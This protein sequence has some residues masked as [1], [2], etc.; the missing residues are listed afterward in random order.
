M[1]FSLCFKFTF[2]DENQLSMGVRNGD[3]VG[4]NLII[5]SGNDSCPPLWH[6]ALSNRI[7]AGSCS[8]RPFKTD[9]VRPLKTTAVVEWKSISWWNMPAQSEIA[10]ISVTFPPRSPPTHCYTNTCNSFSKVTQSEQIE[11]G[12]YHVRLMRTHVMLSLFPES[13]SDAERLCPILQWTIVR[14]SLWKQWHQ[15]CGS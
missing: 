10:A 6:D 3:Q 15:I 9:I 13:S 1:S 14:Q 2:S 12:F 7:M 11:A 8:N 5:L 4:R